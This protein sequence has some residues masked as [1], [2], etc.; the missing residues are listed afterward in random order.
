M[1][2][3]L[4]ALTLALLLA[5]CTSGAEPCISGSLCGQVFDSGGVAIVG[6][7]VRLTQV[8]TGVQRNVRADTNGQWVARSLEPGNW[9]IAI[10]MEGFKTYRYRSK[11]R[12]TPYRFEPKH[13]PIASRIVI[14]PSAKGSEQ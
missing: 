11:V 2:R 4:F 1:T 8:D 13:R 9:E 14:V 12:C 5:A 6:A 7:N 10:S 3:H